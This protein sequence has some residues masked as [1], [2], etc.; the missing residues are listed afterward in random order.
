MEVLKRSLLDGQNRRFL[1]SVA[2][3]CFLLLLLPLAFALFF[4]NRFGYLLLCQ[5]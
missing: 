5:K 4:Q 1:F 2:A 3:A